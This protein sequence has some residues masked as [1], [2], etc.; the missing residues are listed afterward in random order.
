MLL[1]Y[2][3]SIFPLFVC[4]HEVCV[5]GCVGIVS[6]K[7]LECTYCSCCCHEYNTT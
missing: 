5:L 7:V 6:Q 2:K 3:L 4:V 1:V